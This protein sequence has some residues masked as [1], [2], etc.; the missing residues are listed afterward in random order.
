[1]AMDKHS[2]A[3]LSDAG[4]LFDKLTDADLMRRH[5]NDDQNDADGLDL[6]SLWQAAEGRA[7][8][9]VMLQISQ[10]FM[11][12]KQCKAILEKGAIAYQPSQ[13][14]ASSASDYRHGGDFDIRILPSAAQDGLVYVQLLFHRAMASDSDNPNV[15]VSH[16]DG[17]YRQK[18]LTPI[19]DQR[20]QLLWHSDDPMLKDLRDPETELYIK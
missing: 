18:P 15:L 9:A 14:A 8:D 19:K 6:H 13:A 5:L 12:R 16:R 2:K 1:M 10:D 4:K 11:A 17:V 7:N 3:I 20:I